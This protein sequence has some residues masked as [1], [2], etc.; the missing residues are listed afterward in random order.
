MSFKDLA[1]RKD[2]LAACWLNRLTAGNLDGV[3]PQIS[4]TAQLPLITT[5]YSCCTAQHSTTGGRSD[6]LT[7]GVP[8]VFSDIFINKHVFYLFFVFLGH[9]FALT[10]CV[11]DDRSFTFEETCHVRSVTSVSVALN[12]L[13]INDSKLI[14][15]TDKITLNSVREN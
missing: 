10:M 1:V 13:H 5:Q 15:I 3:Q 7:Q 4:Y 11:T 2:H 8:S 14:N 6:P 9:F 12:L